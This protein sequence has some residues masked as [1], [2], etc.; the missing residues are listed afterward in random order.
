MSRLKQLLYDHSDW[1]QP[2]SDQHTVIGIPHTR[3]HRKTFVE[4]G[5][6][7]SPGVGT[8]GVSIWVYDP[9]A[10]KLWAPEELPLE[11]LDWHWEGG[12]LPVLNSTWRAGK[13]EIQQQLL[14]ATLGNLENIV[15]TLRV[16]VVSRSEL[17]AD[18]SGN[19]VRLRLYLVLRPYGPAGGQVKEL[20]V[21]SSSEIA[22]NGKTVLLTQQAGSFGAVA[23]NLDGQD[24]SVPLRNGNL[25]TA[26][27]VTDPDGLCGGAL[28]YELDLAAD[29]EKE[30]IFDFFV[31]PLEQEYLV[32]F[33]EYHV[34]SYAVKLYKISYYWE[35]LL[36]VVKL[37]LPDRQFVNAFYSILAQLLVATC[38]SDVRI[39]T[40]TYPF[41]WLRDG[42]YIINALDKAGL[43][44]EMRLQLD[45]IK[46]GLF[47]G[48]FGAEPD[49]F[50]EAIWPFYTH[51]KLTADCEWLK[52]V[53]PH[54][55]KR[56]DWIIKVRHTTEY[57][58]DDT[59]VRVPDR[60]YSASTDLICEPARDGLIQGRMDWH[61]PLIW[62]NAFAYMGL[63]AIAEMAEILDLQEEAS[64]YQKE[65]G[66]IRDALHSFA[67]KNFGTNERD[68][69]CAI[70]PTQAFEPDSELL[71]ELYD[72][73]WRQ[74]RLDQTGQY[75]AEPL[76]KY[77]EL[78]QAHNYL[79]LGERTRALET[80]D[81]YLKHHDVKNLFGW[82]E[83]S[84][85]I[86]ENWSQIEGWYKF[87][88]RQPH[89]WVSSEFFL[90][91]RDTL[92][93]EK[94]GS[95]VLGQGIPQ[96]WLKSLEPLEV[97]NAPSTF[98]PV[99]FTIS[100]LFSQKIS[101]TEEN[102]KITIVFR[103]L[104]RLPMTIEIGLPL[105]DLSE[106]V[107]SMNRSERESQVEISQT[108]LAI[109][110]SHYAKTGQVELTIKL[111]TEA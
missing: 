27:A 63:A 76:W 67:I 57:L 29:E 59:E 14:A 49:A 56:A 105:G 36:K 89:G 72:K 25:P 79:L 54:L 84:H 38:G 23:Y 51:F 103:E 3:D 15:N 69:V 94:A 107:I 37:K 66:E 91:L 86:A 26:Q 21:V 68:F 93:Y 92:L 35:Q 98:G 48:G 102:L 58:Y 44:E 53:Y 104:T 109:P 9:D 24:I 81:Y 2:R 47:A 43:H 90:L 17:K 65:A 10:S 80:I 99:D 97:L 30:F 12:Y 11:A 18:C 70:W 8:F 31:H 95:L 32:R 55:K 96:A 42:V 101:I 16:R 28:A 111:R 62:I 45:R 73:W 46:A 64:L 33:K 83:D 13:F 6:N 74:I 39:A 20:S 78:G 71:L 50:G 77:F 60:R 7:F 34:Q 61:R 5:G 100:R 106:A 41:F 40:V 87:P 22:V 108:P 75:K 82:L 52:E 1:I 19:R 85:D 110:L 88:S 4:P